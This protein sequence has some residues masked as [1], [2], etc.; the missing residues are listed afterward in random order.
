MLQHYLEAD[1]LEYNT[2]SSCHHMFN[3]RPKLKLCTGNTS[4]VASMILSY[5]SIVPSYLIKCNN[6]G[7]C[8]DLRGCPQSP[9]VIE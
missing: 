1:H 2:R 9:L 7:H 8:T 5:G 4:S 3:F 6:C